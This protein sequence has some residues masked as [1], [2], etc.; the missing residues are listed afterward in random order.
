MRTA[1]EIAPLGS[2]VTTKSRSVAAAEALGAMAMPS[3]R[4][5]SCAVV[6]WSNPVTFVACL[7]E[8]E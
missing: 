5:L 2:M 4:A 7:D 1:S 3:A 6:T 8:I